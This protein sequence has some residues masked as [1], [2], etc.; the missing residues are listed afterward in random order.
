MHGSDRMIAK[1]AHKNCK[2]LV[3]DDLGLLEHA[4]AAGIRVMDWKMF[5]RRVVFTQK[6]RA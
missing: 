2:L 6:R 4:M 3:S 1:A 5:L